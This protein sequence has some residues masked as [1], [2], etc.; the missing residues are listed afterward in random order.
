MRIVIS[1]KDGGVS[2][3]SLHEQAAEAAELAPEHLDTVITSEI[4][5]WPKERQDQVVSWQPFPDDVLPADR[6]FRNAWVAHP[7]K[8]IDVDMAKA[9]NIQ[10][11]RLRDERAPL[12]AALDIEYQRADE[13][14]DAVA[15]RAIAVKKQ[16]L[17]DVT[18]D[19]AIEAAQTP[20][21]LKAV[22]PDV[23]RITEE[24]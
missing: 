10:R 21:A 12:L 19:P 18:D 17:R 3:M 20:E 7:D 6:H 5:Q 23:L 2:I 1:R 16:A 4:S 22:M 9:R 13:V 8:G 24:K 15:K 11:D 14:Q